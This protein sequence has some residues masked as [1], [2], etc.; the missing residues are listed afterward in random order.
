[1]AFVQTYFSTKA[2]YGQVYSL[3]SIGSQTL[4]TMNLFVNSVTGIDGGPGRGTSATTAYK[5]F[6]QALKDAFAL[7]TKFQV[8]INLAGALPHVMPDGDIIPLTSSADQITTDTTPSFGFTQQG[9]LVIR[10]DPT[11]TATLPIIT[12]QADNALSGLKEIT[13][14]GPFVVGAFDGKW[15]RDGNG[16][17]ARIINNT[18][19][20]INI[21]YS[22]P[23]LVAPL[24]V[25][26]AGATITPFAPG[27]LNPTVVIRGGSAPVVFFGIDISPSAGGALQ[28]GPNQQAI[29]VACG[30]PSMELGCGV[31]TDICGDAAIEAFACKLGSM[32]APQAEVNLQ[33]S[34]M[35]SGTFTD[36]SAVTRVFANA[37]AFTSMA[38]GLFYDG[39]N[40][41]GLFQGTNLLVSSA[42]GVGVHMSGGKLLLTICDIT[43]NGGAGIFCEDGCTANLV[44][45]GSSVDNGGTGIVS[46]T[47]S[48]V[49]VADNGIFVTGAGNFDLQVGLLPVQ[50]YANFILGSQPNTRFD[51]AQNSAIYFAPGGMSQVPTKLLT[52]PFP[53]YMLLPSDSVILVNGTAGA[54]FVLLPPLQ[55]CE[56][57][58]YTIKKVD[59]SGNPVSIDGFGGIQTIDG[60]LTY[61]LI[62]QYDSITIVAGVDLLGAP[63]WN[64]IAK[65]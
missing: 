61:P 63:E 21:C 2:F 60:G 14:P 34:L 31:N 40:S 26:T 32:A 52:A 10:A 15:L 47:G 51:A 56:G 4:Q 1:M 30:I 7:S 27:S 57:R 5:S 42:A 29:F 59:P 49:S 13:L 44:S 55:S 46:L 25:Q 17:L 50:S 58:Q 22:G 3:Q 36:L 33:N 6:K 24:F 64:V 38:S 11:A 20:V 28:V 39:V 62:A 41:V 35:T 19:N 54:S 43:A 8:I 45:C 9:P 23:D 16:T 48:R 65:V 53:L 12:S 18:V 37:C